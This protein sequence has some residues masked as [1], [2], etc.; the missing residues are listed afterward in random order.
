MFDFKVPD[1]CNVEDYEGFVWIDNV[2]N[3]AAFF[4]EYDRNPNLRG[5]TIFVDDARGAREFEMMIRE[6]FRFRFNAASVSNIA[7]V[8]ARGTAQDCRKLNSGS[9][10]IRKHRFKALRGKFKSEM[11]K[12]WEKEVDRYLLGLPESHPH[13]L[14][15]VLDFVLG[16]A[17][18]HVVFFEEVRIILH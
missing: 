9:T 12:K 17:R 3:F 8:K 11:F 16:T 4:A 14:A 18:S 7:I 15:F 6:R 5:K 2:K 13:C 1:R 10:A